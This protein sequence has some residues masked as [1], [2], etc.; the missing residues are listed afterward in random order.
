MTSINDYVLFCRWHPGGDII[1]HFLHFLYWSRDRCLRLDSSFLVMEVTWALCTRL[2][3]R[4]IAVKWLQWTRDT[5]APIWWVVLETRVNR[6]ESIQQHHH[7]AAWTKWLIFC[8]R[9]FQIHF[10]E[11]ILLYVASNFTMQDRSVSI[12]D[13]ALEIKQPCTKPSIW[14]R[15]SMTCA[16]FRKAI[17]CLLIYP[18]KRGPECQGGGILPWGG[19]RDPQHPAHTGP[20]VSGR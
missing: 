11:W 2:R 1:T 12:D 17:N 19:S 7:N 18:G 15:K 13:N 20:L 10:L 3:L 6:R 4:Q 5:V 14:L 9:R 8:R 16:S